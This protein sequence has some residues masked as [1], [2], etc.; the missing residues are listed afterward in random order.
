MKK[1]LFTIGLVLGSAIMA[2]AAPANPGPY[3]VR[4]PDGSVIL[5]TLH[6]DEFCHWM[7][8]QSGIIVEKDPDGFWRPSGKAIA[9][10]RTPLQRSAQ[11]QAR[12]KWSSYDNPPVTNFGDRTIPALLINFSDSTFVVDDPKTRFH[13]LLNQEGY[14]ENGG[15]GSVRDYYMD[16]SL[17]Q[18]RPSFE[19]L[20]PVTLSQSSA[21]YDKNG[22][23]KAIKEAFEILDPEVD[24]SKYDSDGD[25]NIDM[26]LVYYA[27]H[28]EAEG[29]GEESIWPHQ[30]TMYAT[31]DGVVARKYFCTS[32]LF[33]ATGTEMCGIGT[34]VHEFA[35]SLGLPD[36]YD[37]DYET[38][39]Q[40]AYTTDKFDVMCRGNYNLRG[41]CPP[42]FTALER[43][44]LGWMKEPE[45]IAYGGSYS[46]APLQE[47]AAYKFKT[48]NEGEYLILETRNG[49]GWDAG[50][51]ETGLAVYHVDQS[52]NNVSGNTAAYLWENTNKINAYY[53]HPCYYIIDNAGGL[54]EKLVG[55][56]FGGT[57]STANSV[58]LKQWSGNYAGLDLSEITLSGGITTFTAFISAESTLYGTVKDTSG[59]PIEGAQV[60]L[61]RA[62]YPF[63]GAPSVLPTDIVAETDADGYYSIDISGLSTE[64]QVLSVRKTGY[65]PVSENITMSTE[66]RCIRN[67]TLF[68]IDECP[69]TELSKVSDTGSLSR[70]GMGSG[71]FAVAMRYTK[72]E[73]AQLGYAGCRLTDIRFA[74]SECTYTDAYLLVYFDD[75]LALFQKIDNLQFGG[76]V[77]YD[78]QGLDIVLP[79]GKDVY[80]GYGLTGVVSGQHPFFMRENGGTSLGGNFARKDFDTTPTSWRTVWTQYDYLIYAGLELPAPEKTPDSFDVAYIKMVDGVPQAVPQAGKTLKDVSWFLDG[81]PVAEPQTVSGAHTFKAV[82]RYYDGTSETLWFDLR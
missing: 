32:E 55:R 70:G 4:Q 44:M 74:V 30:A 43:H 39:G 14:S 78:I 54:P 52:E 51:Q 40:N 69:K 73:I 80:I 66:N 16:N 58:S 71:N 34:T 45:L 72:D 1:I 33:G 36:F 35:H 2:L 20:G 18:Y 13:N 19:V 37:T 3:K 15:Y 29:A 6:G 62:A 23:S 5:L 47:N 38:G 50:I 25:G 76:I 75:D 17:G 22:V 61:S 7:T 82:L 67:F 27:G 26:I 28:N 12:A 41:K 63:A 48:K 56:L 64:D 60:V 49:E 10:Y 8:N 65:I 24:F 79:E 68:G 9:Q 77:K 81:A 53:G 21:Y 42:Y 31:F 46:L 59:K 57:N 11:I